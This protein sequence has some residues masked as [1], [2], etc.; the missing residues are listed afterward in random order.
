MSNDELNRKIEFIVEQQAQFA[1]DIQEL[2][3]VVKVLSEVANTALESASKTSEI[4]MT[5]I[6]RYQELAAAQTE[7]Q[8]TVDRLARAVLTHVGDGHG[9]RGPASSP[10]TA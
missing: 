4:S 9:G 1:S 5:L 8:R 6:E 10:P 7:T 3:D 2:K